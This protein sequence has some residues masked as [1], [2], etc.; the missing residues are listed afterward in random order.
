MHTYTRGKSLRFMNQERE[1]LGFMIRDLFHIQV[2]MVSSSSALLTKRFG[3]K[4]LL[5]LKTKK[6]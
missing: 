6:W 2:V 4:A 3:P 1:V 5:L